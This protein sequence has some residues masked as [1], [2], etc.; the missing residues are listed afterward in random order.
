MRRLSI[1]LAL[2]P[3]L[4][5]AAAAA[6]VPWLRERHSDLAGSALWALVLLVSWVGWGGVIASWLLP[7]PRLDWG[8]RSALGMAGMIA[9]GGVLQI[10]FLVRPAV[11]VVL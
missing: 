1:P 2:A 9:L 3:S 7:G 4:L 6:C 11:V 10:G 8:L 5:V